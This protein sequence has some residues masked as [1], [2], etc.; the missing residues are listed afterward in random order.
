MAHELT[1]AYDE[2]AGTLVPNDCDSRACTEIRAYDADGGCRANGRLLQI[3]ETYQQCIKRQAALSTSND[4]K[5]GN[6]KASV[7]RM[8]KKCFGSSLPTK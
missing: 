8:F 2:C 1:H 3:G 4:P 7:D 6:G 5:C